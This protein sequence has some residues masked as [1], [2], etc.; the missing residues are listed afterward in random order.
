[1]MRLRVP[2]WNDPKMSLG[3]NLVPSVC[4]CGDF[5]AAPDGALCPPPERIGAGSWTEYGFA[6][7]AGTGVYRKTF[8][9]N[10]LPRLPMLV[11][12]RAGS[13]VEVKLNGRELA[14]RCWR[15]WRFALDGALRRGENELEIR[16][17]GT[18]GNL[19]NRGGWGTLLRS[20][21]VA[22]GL[23]GPVRITGEGLNGVTEKL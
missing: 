6:A 5:A 18:F 19:L 23:I 10:D 9:L 4:L 1:M 11:I 15:P 16:V 12:D 20:E 14:P 21:P 17:S 22:Y 13:T 3:R 8:F 2:V 7:F